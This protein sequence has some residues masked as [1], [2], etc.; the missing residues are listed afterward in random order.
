MEFSDTGL[1]RPMQ[2]VAHSNAGSANV[3]PSLGHVFQ[4]WEVT[5]RPSSKMSFKFECPTPFVLR[6][7]IYLWL[8]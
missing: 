3:L 2:A 4:D 5:N 8:V 7:F 1:M 6:N